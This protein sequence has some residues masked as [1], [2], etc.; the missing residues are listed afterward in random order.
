MYIILP[1]YNT[2]N[3]P[4]NIISSILIYHIPIFDESGHKGCKTN[5]IITT[6]G[7]TKRLQSEIGREGRE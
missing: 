5:A 7:E 6:T 1:I 4:S 2:I 3:R